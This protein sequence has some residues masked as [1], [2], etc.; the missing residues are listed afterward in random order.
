MITSSSSYTLVVLI[1]VLPLMR[2]GGG[3]PLPPLWGGRGE[4]AAAAA[5]SLP[6]PPPSYNISLRLEWPSPP[7][8]FACASGCLS[9]QAGP[10]VLCTISSPHP[11]FIQCIHPP[12]ITHITSPTHMLAPQRA[13]LPPCGVILAPLAVSYSDSP[14]HI[15]WICSQSPAGTLVSSVPC[16]QGHVSRSLRRLLLVACLVAA[17]LLL[18][19]EDS[20]GCGAGERGRAVEDPV[21]LDGARLALAV[22]DHAAVQQLRAAQHHGHV[23]DGVVVGASSHD[24]ELTGRARATRAGLED[25]DPA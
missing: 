20:C 17:V 11:S 9:T 19:A 12:I 3:A 24:L 2:R 15:L 6:D 10:L 25:G 18:P 1:I 8:P 16:F 4:A 22:H 23:R 5:R 13:W 14:T 7:P 21:A